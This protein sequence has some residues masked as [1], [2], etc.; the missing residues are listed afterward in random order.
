MRLQIASSYGKLFV[1]KINFKFLCSLIVQFNEISVG[2]RINSRKPVGNGVYF[3]FQVGNPWTRTEYNE[4][5]FSKLNCVRFNILL[6]N[7]RV[8]N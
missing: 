3:P 2:F 4:P 8:I 1:K 6:H 7:Q 5:I